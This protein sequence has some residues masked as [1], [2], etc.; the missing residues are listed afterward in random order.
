MKKSFRIILGLIALVLVS[1]T[2]CKKYSEGPMLSLRSKKARLAGD[3]KLDKVT[4]NGAD[5]SSQFISANATETYTYD[6]DGTW[7]YVYTSGTIS[8]NFTG[9]WEFV[10]KK[11][12]LK[13]TI[14]G[15]TDPDGD[16]V[17]I[18]RLKNKEFWTEQKSGSDTYRFE[19]VPK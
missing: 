8:L 15:S 4:K 14:D 1:I 18:V 9:K 16:T 3:W 5:V 7:K 13:S 19:Y 17:T 12:N 10:Y 6:K 2:A 11:E